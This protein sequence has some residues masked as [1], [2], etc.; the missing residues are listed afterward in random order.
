[1]VSRSSFHLGGKWEVYL[2]RLSEAGAKAETCKGIRWDAMP[3]RRW[4]TYRHGTKEVFHVHRRLNINDREP[5]LFRQLGQFGL[6]DVT[7]V[8][9]CMMR[10]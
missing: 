6:S 4:V 2:P 3:S 7:F 9:S 10:R 1:M 5:L 8:S